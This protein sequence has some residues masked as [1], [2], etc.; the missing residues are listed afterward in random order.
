[1]NLV[2]NVVVTN[3]KVNRQVRITWNASTTP[4]ITGYKVYKSGVPY[5]SFSLIATLPTTT[6]SYIDVIETLPIGE[7]F[8]EVCEY[9]G[10]TLGPVPAY[11]QT[12][13]NLKA[14]VQDPFTGP[15]PVYPTNPQMDYWLEEIRRRNVWLLQ[16]DGEDMLLYKRRFEGTACPKWDDGLQQCSFPLDRATPCYGTGYVGGYYPAYNLKIRRIVTP[17][18][19]NVAGVGY[20]LDMKPRMWTVW[21]PRINAGDFVVTQENKRYMITDVQQHTV[22]GLILHQ[23]MDMELR[24]PTDMIYKVT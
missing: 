18:T 2:Q 24:L 3:L 5:A 22:R 21:A 23:D 11:G 13:E 20:K 10:A 9:T 1:M 16:Q 14:W 12:Y 7:W 6:T 19:L 15:P 17:F 4:G 8:Y